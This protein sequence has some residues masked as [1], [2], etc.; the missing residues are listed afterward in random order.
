[1]E[2]GLGEQFDI[3][4]PELIQSALHYTGPAPNAD[5][6]RDYLMENGISEEGNEL[7][8][9]GDISPEIAAATISFLDTL[10]AEL[11]TVTIRLT[12]GNDHFH[13]G[14]DYTSR[15]T[16]GDAVDFTVTPA[17]ID[18]TDKVETILQRYAAGNGGYFRY[19]N[20][21][22]NPTRAATGKHFH[23]S[24]GA[25]TEAQ[26]NVDTAEYLASLGTI[27]AIQI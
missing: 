10:Y 8:S 22:D 24:W 1:M 6:L 21:Y 2:G 17:R 5:K 26:A 20:E 16:R 27:E 12:G 25:G 3:E 19:L 14:L 11:P 18:V 15:H 7:S 13:H 9:G 4:S 23:M